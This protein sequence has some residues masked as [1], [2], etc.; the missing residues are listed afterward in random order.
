MMRLSFIFSNIF[1]TLISFS[2]LVLQLLKGIF[3]YL[4]INQSN[5]DVYVALTVLITILGITF[6]TV[7]IYDFVYCIYERIIPTLSVWDPKDIKLRCWDITIIDSWRW[8]MVDSWTTYCWQQE[9]K[10]MY[11][12]HKNLWDNDEITELFEKVFVLYY[13]VIDHLMSK[14]LKFFFC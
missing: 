11:D 6:Y 2:E 13:L 7:I 14:R 12:Y 4:G 1:D 10:E 3:I 5:L 8:L 9:Q